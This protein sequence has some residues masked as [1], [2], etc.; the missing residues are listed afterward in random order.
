MRSLLILVL[1]LPVIAWMQACDSP[2]D[3]ETPRNR[4]SDGVSILPGEDIGTP[5]SII[6]PNDTTG[7]DTVWT[8]AHFSVALVFDASGSITPQLIEVYRTAA[9]AFLDSLDGEIDQGA[10]ICFNDGA[11][12]LQHM[13]TDRPS[14]RSAV[15][16]IPRTGPTALWDGIYVGL[17]E[18]QSRGTHERR[19]LVVVTDGDDNSSTTGSPAAIIDLAQRENIVVYSISMLATAKEPLLRNV[20]TST[21]GKHYSRPVITQLTEIYRELARTLR[22]P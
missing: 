7:G 14:M 10:V 18:L 5:I 6:I 3:V 22:A 4:Y 1:M 13:T 19:A 15:S 11:T 21:G 16:T 8:P 20:A 2:L 12:I 9:N 17:L